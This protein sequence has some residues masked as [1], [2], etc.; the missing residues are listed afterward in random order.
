M[1]KLILY[2]C[3]FC[4]LTPQLFTIEGKIAA[5]VIAHSGYQPREY[6][7]TREKIEGKN[8]K[9]GIKVLIVSDKPG[10]AKSE[11]SKAKVDKTLDEITTDDYDGIFFI[12]G[13]GALSYLDNKQSY[14]V[15]Q[16][17]AAANKVYG[18]ICISPR[19]LAKAGVLTGKN[20]TGWNGD[21]QLASIF[22][23][24]GVNYVREDVVTDGNTI[25]AIGP[26]AAERFG[27]GIIEL[28]K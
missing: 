4:I 18:A 28:L 24:H 12:G 1:K 25:T 3:L 20:A 15:L 17:A 6:E 19:I 14:A 27:Q 7:K 16:D 26:M 11:G 22:R 2:F 9:T 8:K 13:P 21:H 23:R 10:I 5:L